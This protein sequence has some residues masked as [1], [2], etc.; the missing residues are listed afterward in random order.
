MAITYFGNNSNGDGT[1]A[2]EA[3]T[4]A[5]TLFT[6]STVGNL[7]ELSINLNSAY[8]GNCR[9]GVYAYSG[10][11]TQPGALLLDAGE[12][13]N[14]GSGWNTKSSLTLAVTATQY[15]LCVIP[16]TDTPAYISWRQ[17]AAQS[18][19]YAVRSGGYGA[20]PDP[21]PTIAGTQGGGLCMRAGVDDGAAP[22]GGSAADDRFRFR[23]SQRV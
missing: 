13:T 12:F 7:T 20:L 18:N 5:A 1:G 3:G 11:S 14:P 19:S 9:I 10:S 6:N 22:P 15:W 8:T 23:P 21:C 2:I 4:I 16:S 17:V